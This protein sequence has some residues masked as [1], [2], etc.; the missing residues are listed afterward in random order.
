[1]VI[2]LKKGI[3]EQ[4]KQNLRDFLVRN[5]FRV[6]EITGEEDTIFGAVGKLSIDPREVE[7]L[8]GVERVIPISK[9]YKMASREYKK[10]NTV[11][12][13]PNNRGQIIRIGG[14]RVVAIAGPCAVESRDQMM[15]VAQRVAAAGAVMLRGG[16]FKPRTS[17]Y[18]F[19]GMG[20]A[21]VK[22]LK[23]AGNA[24]GLPVVTEIVSAEHI[25]LMNDYVDVYQIGARNMQNFELLK[26]VGELGKPVILKRGLSATI[27]EWLMAAEYLLSAG[28][29]KVVLCERGIRTYER[30]TRN[31]LD[32]SAIPVLRSLTHLPII[33]DPSHAV[34][35]RDKVP[36]MGL[37]AIAA[38]AD[39]IIVEVHCD[40]DKA[41]SDG[42]QSLYPEQFEKLMRDIDVLAPVVGKEIARIR[43]V[44]QKPA[45]D[46]TDTAEAA[47]Q[48]RKTVC[49][50]SGGHGAYAEQAIGLYFDTAAEALPLNSF[51]E[52]FQAVADGRADFGMV[53]IENSLAGSV[54]DNYDNLLRFEDVSITGALTLRIEHS[55]LAVPGATLDTIKNV[56]SHPHG[57]PQCKDFLG[58]HPQWVHID[59][60]ST[61]TAA[62]TV[63]AK[64]SPEN[65]AI[66][67]GVTAEYNN[68]H[69]LATGIE[70]DPRNYT[71]FVV[72]AANHVREPNRPQPAC[73]CAAAEI[74]AEINKASIAFV[75]K[76]EPGAL[77]DC[78]GVFHDRK[79]NMTRLES[80]PIQGQP[81]R[82][83]FYA[84]VQFPSKDVATGK[85]VVEDALSALKTKA[86]DVRL[87][88]MYSERSL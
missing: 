4:D 24:Y 86:E 45:A 79:L 10:D 16:A 72:I 2:V 56:Y 13:I 68:L 1:M 81:W 58:A 28:T 42:A 55:L 83:M 35:I 85:K 20:E 60:I 49:A 8:P 59:S 33:V 29:D 76:N 23:E 71:R 39:G 41:M 34:G 26:R 7:I 63:A 65:A 38:G 31:T 12:E 88:G 84:D 67:S 6:N 37:A 18:A 54:Y 27:E 32:L 87:L 53:P 69:I 43:A 15:A 66:A 25:P 36:P 52:I 14:Q 30:A 78:L 5:K 62:E 75:A 50:Y 40:P 22:I 64:G 19:Q 61:A 21:G 46:T 11:I 3:P 57:F 80:R 17:P 70:S 9:P 44:P 51:R 47:G 73:S 82:Y 48:N 77:Y 74:N